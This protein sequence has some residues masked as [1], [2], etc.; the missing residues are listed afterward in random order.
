VDVD[1]LVGRVDVRRIVDELD[2]DAL[3]EQ[4]ELGAIIAKST[5][6]VASELLDVVRAQGVGLDDFFAR[7]T[8]RLLRRPASDLPTGPERL[9]GP[10]RPVPDA[11]AARGTV[12]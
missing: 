2:I 3:V 1:A 10:D 7:W 9:V 4:T 12:R 6:G 8:N 5:T 11:G